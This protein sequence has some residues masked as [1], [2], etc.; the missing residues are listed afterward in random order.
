MMKSGKAVVL[1]VLWGPE[2][3]SRPCPETIRRRGH[4]I[5]RKNTAMNSEN[6]QK[7]KVIV[8]NDPSKEGGVQSWRALMVKRKSLDFSCG[9]WGATEV[10]ERQDWNCSVGQ[11]TLEAE[12]ERD[13]KRL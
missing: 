8:R 1:T 13:K 5:Q 7:H 10:G 11:L 6:N 4:S 9:Q 2:R 12:R 3:C